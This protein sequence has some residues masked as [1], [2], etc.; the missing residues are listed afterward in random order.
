MIFLL[1][2]ERQNGQKNINEGERIAL[3]N[4]LNI[5]RTSIET[6]MT[7]IYVL[8]EENSVFRTKMTESVKVQGNSEEARVLAKQL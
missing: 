2:K 6:L 1:N 8:T 5:A 4:E 7:Q 3:I